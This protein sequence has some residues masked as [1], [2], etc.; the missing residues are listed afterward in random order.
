VNEFDLW[1]GRLA[2][3]ASKDTAKMAVTQNSYQ[4]ESQPSREPAQAFGKLTRHFAIR[5]VWRTKLS[6]RLANRLPFA[7]F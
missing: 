2:R 1:H 3:A 6:K 4:T 7:E 5:F